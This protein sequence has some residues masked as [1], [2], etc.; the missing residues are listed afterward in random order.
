MFM[1]GRAVC[2]CVLFLSGETEV[3]QCGPTVF[4]I[5]FTHDPLQR[6]LGKAG[7]HLEKY[8]RMYLLHIACGSSFCKCLEAHLIRLF[9]GWQGCHNERLGG[10][11]PDQFPGPYFC[12][13]VTKKA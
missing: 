11:G 8:E 1:G 13:L 2:V 5:G 3:V 9:C 12:Y 6:M 7:Y 10:E 4:K